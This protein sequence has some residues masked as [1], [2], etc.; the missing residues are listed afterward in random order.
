MGYN[1]SGQLGDGTTNNAHAPE[2]IVAS[3][4]V[5]IAAGYDHS[6]FLKS[7]GSAWGMGLNYDGE[8]G[9]GAGGVFGS[10]TNTPE[11]IVA[12]NVVAIAAGFGYSLFLKSDGSVWATGAIDAGW[13]GDGTTTTAY[14]NGLEQIVSSNVVAIAAG[15][16]HN[17]FLKSDGS[18]WGVG[19]N[20]AGQLGDGT[21][22][23]TN[24]LQQI[25]PSGVVAISGGGE[26]SLFLK[27][28][29]SLWA[30]GWNNYGQLGDGFV[31]DSWTPEQ[32]F[33]LPQPVLTTSFSSGTGLQI[34]A[35]TLFGGNFYLLAG[36]NFTLPLQ[37]TPV[38]T[39]SV[40]MRGTNNFSATLTNAVNASGR[41]FYILQSQ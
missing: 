15:Q 31:G 10:Y 4:V 40:T 33:P 29:G 7:D 1:N 11:M 32:I 36:T 22:N 39:N 35:T 24:T 38:W 13:I 17:L 26:H 27:S 41:Q 9:D 19:W 16:Y 21:A 20:I 2:Q 12:S 5:A 23:S 14:T 25:V 6:L 30:M 34:N 8:L 37:W 3:N 18:L 28:D